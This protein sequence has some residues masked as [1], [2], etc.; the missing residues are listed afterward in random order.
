MQRTTYLFNALHT[1]GHS[2]AQKACGQSTGKR[3]IPRWYKQLA[4]RGDHATETLTAKPE[5][6]NLPH[7]QAHATDHCRVPLSREK[8]G[9][10]SKRRL[11][12]LC[13]LGCMRALGDLCGFALIPV[14]Q[15]LL[16]Q[17]SSWQRAGS[18]GNEKTLKLAPSTYAGQ[19]PLCSVSFTSTSAGEWGKEQTLP[20]ETQDVL[21]N[22]LHQHV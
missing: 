13:R 19:S 20:S 10:E 3:K 5:L 12:S 2:K 16:S 6:W 9:D 4:R 7:C 21:Y 18:Q 8:A 11:L 17:C 14:C 22:H 15:P 1:H